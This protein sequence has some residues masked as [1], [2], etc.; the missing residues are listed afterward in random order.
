MMSRY[1]T[2]ILLLAFAAGVWICP[3]IPLWVSV[4]A[5][6]LAVSFGFFLQFRG[7]KGLAGSPA[8]AAVFVAAVFFA[9]AWRG[10]VHFARVEGTLSAMPW[11]HGL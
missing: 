10:S 1:A 3:A 6:L 8:V 2:A 7:K 5:A 4:A 9:G 11:Y